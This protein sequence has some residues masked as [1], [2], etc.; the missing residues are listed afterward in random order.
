MGGFLGPADGRGRER[1]AR[2]LLADVDRRP[3]RVRQFACRK[4]HTH[5]AAST[6][7]LS[8]STPGYSATKANKRR[9]SLGRSR[10]GTPATCVWAWRT[11]SLS[12]SLPYWRSYSL[13]RA[14]G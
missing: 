11:S 2:N 14:C 8:S 3:C 10:V 12:F 4:R 9:Q 1:L 13:N 5:F 7:R 6:E